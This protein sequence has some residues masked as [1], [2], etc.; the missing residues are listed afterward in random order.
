[1]ER[2]LEGPFHFGRHHPHVRVHLL[3]QASDVSLVSQ[4]PT[5]LDKRTKEPSLHAVHSLR[6]PLDWSDP[7]FDY[8]NSLAKLARRERSVTRGDGEGRRPVL[9]TRVRFRGRARLA[10]APAL[11]GKEAL[12]AQGAGNMAMGR[13]GEVLER[14]R[15]PTDAVPHDLATMLRT[16]VGVGVL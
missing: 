6:P 9:R 4:I 16:I 1:M 8:C 7:A 13:R 15:H 2:E 5:G 11:G 14:L 12:G 3:D 10:L